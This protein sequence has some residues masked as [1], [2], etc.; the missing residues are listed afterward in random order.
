M[1]KKAKR[2][3]GVVWPKLVPCNV[4]IHQNQITHLVAEGEG[5]HSMFL[6]EEVVPVQ[7]VQHEVRLREIWLRL[8]SAPDIDVLPQDHLWEA[9]RN[10]YFYSAV[11]YDI[12][13]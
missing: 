4:K 11:V 1:K 13:I 8:D 12:R 3:F 6:P 7:A 9:I 2:L 5:R 10:K